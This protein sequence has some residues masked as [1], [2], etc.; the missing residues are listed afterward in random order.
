MDGFEL[1]EADMSTIARLETG[2]RTGTHP[3]W[4]YVSHDNKGK[5]AWYDPKGN[6]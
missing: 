6:S 2:Q 3:A 1:S 5:W 4:Q